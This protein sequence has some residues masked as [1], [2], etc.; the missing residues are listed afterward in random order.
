MMIDAYYEA[1]GW[2]TEGLIPKSKLIALGLEEIADEIGVARSAL[3]DAPVAAKE[4]A[5]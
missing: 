2:T 3:Q 1:R 5:R 4:E